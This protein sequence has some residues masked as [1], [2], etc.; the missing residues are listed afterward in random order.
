MAPKYSNIEFSFKNS[1]DL[2]ITNLEEVNGLFNSTIFDYCINCAAYTNVE[3]AGKTPVITYKVNAEGVKNLAL[4]CKKIRLF[5]FKF[6]RIM[7]LTAK[8]KG[9]ILFMMNLIL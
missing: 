2:D 5:S 3:Q 1:K 8:R 4:T 7:F 6:Q 9:H